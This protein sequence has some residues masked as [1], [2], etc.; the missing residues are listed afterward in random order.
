MPRLADR[1]LLSTLKSVDSAWK[2]KLWF[3]QNK[4]TAD[5]YLN[6]QETS[7]V[8]FSFYTFFSSRVSGGTGKHRFGK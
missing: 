3:L 8:Q 5:V 6:I 2:G 7:K 1:V 4:V